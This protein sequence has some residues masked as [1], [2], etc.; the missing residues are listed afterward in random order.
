MTTGAE[1]GLI[2]LIGALLKSLDTV[3]TPIAEGA[4]AL[5]RWKPR[6]PVHFPS[7]VC[8]LAAKLD[9][10]PASAVFPLRPS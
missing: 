2:K 9:K 4:A 10:S 5:L 3:L 1:S 8:E 7:F 6:L